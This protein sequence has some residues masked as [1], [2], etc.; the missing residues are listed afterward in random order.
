MIK[1]LSGANRA[2]TLIRKK[3][4]EGSTQ[5]KLH[6]IRT[7]LARSDSRLRSYLEQLATFRESRTY[8]DPFEV[9]IYLVL[10]E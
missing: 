4:V 3:A 1:F 9:D 2:S 10:R 6:R 5:L 7:C 8:S